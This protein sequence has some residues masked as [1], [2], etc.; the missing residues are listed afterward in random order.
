M[1]VVYARALGLMFIRR[2]WWRASASYWAA[3]PLGRSRHLSYVRPV[4]V[5]GG[6]MEQ[7]CT[8]VAMEVTWGLLEA[9]MAHPQRWWVRA[10]AGDAAH[11]KMSQLKDQCP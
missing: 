11:T 8:H 5:A 4:D 7:G 9:G 6:L 3:K 2:R 10:G 1:D